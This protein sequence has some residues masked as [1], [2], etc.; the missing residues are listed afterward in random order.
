M[1]IN[2]PLSPLIPVVNKYSTG[3]HKS[4]ESKINTSENFISSPF[5]AWLLLALVAKASEQK[6]YANTQEN[7]EEYLGMP[8]DE[9]F[10]YA[11][12]LLNTTPEVINTAAALWVDEL[13]SRYPFITEWLDSFKDGVTFDK[14]IPSQAVLDQWASDET[15]GLIKEFPL[16][17]KPDTKL[18]IATAIAT[19]ISWIK[20]FTSVENKD[21][22]I[23]NTKRILKADDDHKQFLAKTED[24]LF[25]VHINRSPDNLSVFSVIGDETLDAQVVLDNAHNI[26][27]SY[28]ARTLTPV[29]LFDID[30]NS[31]IKIK[32]GKRD[33]Q[34][35]MP[36]EDITSY[37]PSWDAKSEM[38]LTD[39]N[40]FEHV[41]QAFI[42]NTDVGG[43]VSVA[44]SAVASYTR[45]GFEA[46]AVTAMMFRAA[47]MP[48][49]GEVDFRHAD[50]LF[51]HPYAVIA[52]YSRT[53]YYDEEKPTPE[54]YIWNG[55]P[56][57]TA[58]IKKA[59]ESDTNAV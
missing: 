49:F 6:K 30:S 34:I 29:S 7:L 44:Q 58:W 3:F 9:A 54:D 41:G 23:W 33:Q 8:I 32:D 14:K 15:Y 17:V 5:G 59:S 1:H 35:G 48:R 25:A 53:S 18:I 20:E 42:K 2:L 36:V 45:T 55:L 57:F 51:N 52:A 10:N 39:S 47:G 46:A 50:V 38:N 11:F 40:G 56:I 4:V 19:K 21:L 16:E 28:L 37:I 22:A 12:E 26:I 43:E 27:E 13:Y 24:G 31:F